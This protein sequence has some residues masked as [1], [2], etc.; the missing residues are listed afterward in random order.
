MRTKSYGG[1]WTLSTRRCNQRAALRITRGTTA[2]TRSYPFSKER[3]PWPSAAGPLEVDDAASGHGVVPRNVIRHCAQQGESHMKPTERHITIALIAL[4]AILSFQC[5][6]DTVSPNVLDNLETRFLSG[7]IS[8]D[9]MPVIP[10][11]PIYCQLTLLAKN[12]SS[13]TSLSGLSMPQAEVFLDSTNQR[14]GTI[15]FST[16]WDGSLGPSEQD[17]V[18][19]TKVVSQTS[20]FTPPCEEYVYLNLIIRDQSNVSITLRLDSLLFT[21]TH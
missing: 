7:Y 1:S 16:T 15:S 8:A 3:A 19:L 4:A 12:K 13:S 20:L 6:N 18:R 14:L 17:T 5:K 21:C 2:R 10:P 11:D 9:L